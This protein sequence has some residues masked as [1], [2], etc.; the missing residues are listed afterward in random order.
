M[1]SILGRSD[2]NGGHIF[3]LARRKS[4]HHFPPGGHLGFHVS[5]IR[6]HLPTETLGRRIYLT[7]G[8]RTSQLECFRW[9]QQPHPPVVCG[10]GSPRL[11]TGMKSSYAEKSL[12]V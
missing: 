12:P 11:C 2:A 10:Q 8:L 9:V 5:V 7:P 4:L 3:L 1:V 6:N